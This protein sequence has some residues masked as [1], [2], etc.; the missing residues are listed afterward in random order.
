M[1]ASEF[2]VPRLRA[3]VAVA[4]PI[5]VVGLG[6]LLATLSGTAAKAGQPG[7]AWVSP[8]ETAAATYDFHCSTC[9]GSTGAGFEE[10]RSRFPADH[11]Q[12]VRCHGPLNPPQMSAVDMDVR[13]TAFSL[14]DPPPLNDRERLATFHTGGELAKYIEAT[15]PR[16]NPGSLDASKVRE[17]TLYVMYLA[18]ILEAT[19]V[20]T[21]GGALLD[22]LR[23]DDLRP[24]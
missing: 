14:G 2:N 23:L 6:V 13:Q 15:M 20:D 22:D 16:W 21:V 17:V 24:R 12:C 10:A 11:A 9:H 7:G 18:G 19:E 5:V 3:L 4:A 1:E 8:F